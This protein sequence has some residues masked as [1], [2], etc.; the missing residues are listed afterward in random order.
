[1]AKAGLLRKTDGGKTADLLSVTSN[2]FGRNYSRHGRRR[3]RGSKRNSYVAMTNDNGH[4]SV[5][6]SIIYFEQRCERT[7]TLLLLVKSMVRW[8]SRTGFL[9]PR[10]L[11]LSRTDEAASSEKRKVR[12]LYVVKLVGH[13]ARGGRRKKICTNDVMSP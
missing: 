8:H 6:H 4:H 2:M 3:W 1:M 11:L 10:V 12:H 13:G 9:L 5:G 7:N